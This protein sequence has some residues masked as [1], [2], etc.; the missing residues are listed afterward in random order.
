LYRITA[1]PKFHF[2]LPPEQIRKGLLPS[3]L[4]NVYFPGFPTLQHIPHAVS[5][6]PFTDSQLDQGQNDQQILLQ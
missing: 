3:V 5:L 2:C 6:N 1:V 4:L